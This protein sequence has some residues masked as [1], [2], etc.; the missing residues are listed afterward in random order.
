MKTVVDVENTVQWLEDGRTDLSPYNP[1]NYLVSCGVLGVDTGASDYICFRHNEEASTL[2]GAAIIQDTLNSTTLLIG[3]NIK[4]D[5]KWL[6]AC[7]FDYDKAIYDTMIHEFLLAG[8]QPIN[9]DLESCCSRYGIPG[10]EDE[11]QALF[12]QKIG[13]EAMPW[14]VVKK[15]GMQDCVATKALYLEQQNG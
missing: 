9:L 14:S 12:K 2:R 7:G 1:K 10:K 4:H 5:L 13:F 3:H 8:G 11:A 15:Y 6:W